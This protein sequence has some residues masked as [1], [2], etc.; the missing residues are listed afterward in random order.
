MDR[1]L[2]P[3]RLSLR[4]CLSLAAVRVELKDGVH[5]AAAAAAGPITVLLR[6]ADH[7]GRVQTWIVLLLTCAIVSASRTSTTT[8]ATTASGS[9]RTPSGRG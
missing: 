1:P 4:D 8:T 3:K 2:Y 6:M 5:I 7:A 9:S